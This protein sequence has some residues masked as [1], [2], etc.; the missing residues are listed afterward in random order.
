MQAIST[1]TTRAATASRTG[2]TASVWA[3]LKKTLR[4]VPSMPSMDPDG[5]SMAFIYTFSVYTV[6]IL[7]SG[8]VL[9]LFG[10]I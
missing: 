3:G 5:W 1:Y 4:R 9:M 7:F 8:A 2:T 10:E 6:W